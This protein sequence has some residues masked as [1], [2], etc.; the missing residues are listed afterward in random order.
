MNAAAQPRRGRR[1]GGEDTRTVILGAARSEFA[2]KGYEGTS[3]RAVARA[4]AVDPA[5]VHHYF[6]GKAHLFAQ[7]VVLTRVNPAKIVGQVLEGP[8]EGLAERLVRAFLTVWDDPVNQERFVALALAA[9]TNDEIGALVREFIDKEIIGRV[10]AQTGI[11]DAR[12][13]GGLAIAQIFGLGT[14]RYVLRLP[15][16]VESSHDEIVTW[17]APTLQRYLVD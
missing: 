9:Q 14:M 8:T 7:A 2:E 6:D 12:V 11:S 15:A 5:L 4:A 13:R 16:L 10:T 17:L 1:P 3:L